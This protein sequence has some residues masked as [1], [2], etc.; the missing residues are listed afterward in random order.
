MCMIPRAVLTA[1]ASAAFAV[2]AGMA[3]GA[4]AAPPLRIMSWN[5][6]HGSGVD[7]KYDLAR[8]AG[9]I[10]ARKPDLV[11]LQEI[12]K[13]CSR[14]SSQD[15][16]SELAKLTGLQAVFAKSCDQDGGQTGLAILT[17]FTPGEVKV[18]TLPRGDEPRVLLTT[19]VE[20]P[21]GPILLA[22]TLLDP[23]NASRRL[24][25]AQIV[26]STLLA[27]SQPVILAGDFND[28]PGTPVL[29]VFAQAPWSPVPKQPPANT[30]PANAPTREVDH[31][32]LRGLR[33]REPAT[34]IADSM[35]SDHRPVVALAAQPK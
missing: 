28:I 16:P 5:I 2:P 17:R 30:C 21:G 4:E 8:I 14:S 19:Q 7:G 3:A 11:M 25:Q 33:A 15:Q 27:V 26:S 35:A 29:T 18:T 10:R 13:Q 24:A 12:D 6:H 9:V 32:I 34:V 1:I 23:N 22:C 31:I 20:T